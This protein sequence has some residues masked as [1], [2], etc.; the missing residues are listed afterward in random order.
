MIT[1]R[2]YQEEAIQ[3][4]RTYWA[5]GGGNP[6]V[7]MATGLGKSV[8]I[9][10][11]TRDL[12]QSYPDMR[13][14]VLVHVRELVEQ[15]FAALLRIWPA[16]PA[17]IYS[18]G[19][20][21]RDAHHR[22]TFASIQS[23]YRKARE[24]GPRDLVL[25]D[26]CHLIPTGGDGMYRTLLEDLRD[27]VPDL[28]VAGFSATPYRM[29]TGRLDQGSARLFDEVV[30]S[31]G[32]GRGIDDEWLSPLISKG[33]VT[34]IDVS[35][36]ARRGGEFVAGALE[37]AANQDDITQG[38][39]EE[40][41][42]YGQGRR[43]WLVFCT[44]VK[45]AWAVREALR[46]AGIGAETI[47]GDTPAAERAGLI[48]AFKEGRIRALTNANVLTTGFDAPS[49][50]MIAMLRPTLST[51]LYVQMIGRGTRKAEGK[52]NCL[53]LDFAGVVKRH[54]P[55]DTVEVGEKGGGE[56]K[57]G[58]EAVNSKECPNCQSLCALALRICRECGHTFVQ[59]EKPKHEAKAQDAPILSRQARAL[60]TVDTVPVLS[61]S[62][63][64]HVKPGSPDS[65]KVTYLAGLLAYPE[66][67]CPEHQ[68]FAKQKAEKFWRQHGGQLPSPS[69]VDEFLARWDELSPPM[70]IGT[71]KNG[72]FF[73]IVSKVFSR[74]EM[75]GA[76]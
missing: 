16:A 18:A 66:W 23:V 6:L 38:A 36:V 47:T 33:M 26:E 11:L 4:V 21:R 41:I 19:L 20:G 42:A 63:C 65:V 22:I 13:I 2:P 8:V 24:L 55:V 62:A 53:I 39:V 52:A 31:Y 35:G 46:G 73:D 71:R 49:V 27:T 72:K 44:G 15:N 40:M 34:S 45:H 74:S 57:V 50:D 3:A 29:D 48:R 17:G 61:W 67:V 75:A 69:T 9:A 64:R 30:Y 76:A 14:L 59:E 70:E 56:G 54:G 68:G 5:A 1:L 37:A 28:R 51:G 32:V 12:L 10:K 60:T 58:L 7:D 43:S 25:V